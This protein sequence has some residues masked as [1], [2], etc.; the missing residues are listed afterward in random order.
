MFY[1]NV[2]KGSEREAL[3]GSTVGAL[4]YIIAAGAPAKLV[5]DQISATTAE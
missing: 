4:L 2:L 3:V 1:L 5:V